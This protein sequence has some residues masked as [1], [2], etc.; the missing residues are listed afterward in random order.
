ML[1]LPLTRQELL[2]AEKLIFA[3]AMF[4]TAN[5]YHSGKLSSLLP[6]R[7][8]PLIITR[9]R[10]GEAGLSGVLGVDALPIL[11]PSSRAAELVMWRAHIG[12][13]GVLHRSVSQTLAISRTCAWIVK[14][15]NLSKKVCFE[16]MVCR[17]ERKKLSSQRMALYKEE[18]LQVCRP[19][20]NISL[21][22]AGPV[23]I[24]GDV[25]L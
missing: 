25:N 18:S 2:D 12:Y 6:E 8:G 10:L 11:M 15:K 9:G 5:A 4:E 13:S 1:K 22:F 7:K 24:K 16:C 23:L 19:W 14:G 3:S 20:T 21:D 17:I